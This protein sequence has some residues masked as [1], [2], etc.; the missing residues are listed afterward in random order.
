MATYL[1]PAK[2]SLV[3]APRNTS[4]SSRRS[5]AFHTRQSSKAHSSA[6]STSEGWIPGSPADIEYSGTR[7]RSATT[8][9]V[10][11][12]PRPGSPNM[13]MRRP[14]CSISSHEVIASKSLKFPTMLDQNLL[15]LLGIVEERDWKDW[16]TGDSSDA[17]KL[18][19]CDLC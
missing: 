19:N 2:L 13:R 5:M 18:P 7:D 8:S 10:N 4:A 15:S 17:L 1:T 6:F 14:L 3:R 9:A 12:F 11:V 16:K